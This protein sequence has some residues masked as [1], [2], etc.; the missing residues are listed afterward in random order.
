MGFRDTHRLIGELTVL[1][2]R[3]APTGLAAFPCQFYCRKTKRLR[4]SKAHRREHQ[5]CQ[6]QAGTIQENIR[7]FTD[8]IPLEGWQLNIIVTTGAILAAYTAL[9]VLLW[10]Y[11]N[12][13]TDD[14]SEQDRSESFSIKQQKTY[15]WK[16]EN[17]RG[18]KLPSKLQK[19]SAKK[20]SQGLSKPKVLPKISSVSRIEDNSEER[21]DF[22]QYKWEVRTASLSQAF[23][24]VTMASIRELREWPGLGNALLLDLFCAAEGFDMWRPLIAAQADLRTV[25]LQQGLVQQVVEELAANIAVGIMGQVLDVKVILDGVFGIHGVQ[26]EQRATG[27]KP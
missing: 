24:G 13:R 12:R 25:K 2:L 14:P 20:P 22:G 1:P 23:A 18:G 11:R 7:E 5:V 27:S 4:R 16:Q 15:D 3:R 10:D 17:I 21:W 8:R 26:T 19:P 6:A 9:Q